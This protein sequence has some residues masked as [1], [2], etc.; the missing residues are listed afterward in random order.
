MKDNL[1][2][3]P[4]EVYSI[5]HLKEV[6]AVQVLSRDN[7]HEWARENGGPIEITDEMTAVG[8][9]ILCDRKSDMYWPHELVR[10]IYAAMEAKRREGK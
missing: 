6:E 7:V 8:A 1:E 9:Y 10:E 2:S 3:I 5:D 4:C